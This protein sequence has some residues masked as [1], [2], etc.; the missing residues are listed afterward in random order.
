MDDYEFDYETGVIYHDMRG[1]PKRQ[2]SFYFSPDGVGRI[3]FESLDHATD[4]VGFPVVELVGAVERR[5]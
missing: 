1:A 5:D 3:W 4:E 2:E